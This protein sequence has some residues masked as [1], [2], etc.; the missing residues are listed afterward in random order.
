MLLARAA[1][2]AGKLK[3]KTPG[4]SVAGLWFSTLRLASGNR[5]LMG[6]HRFLPRDGEP[7]P[8]LSGARAWPLRRLAVTPASIQVAR[9]DRPSSSREV[10]RL[11]PFRRARHCRR[12]LSGY[13]TA[14]AVKKA[15]R[16]LLEIVKR[17]DTAKGLIML[18]PNA[19]LEPL[20]P[21]RQGLREPCPFRIAP[22]SS[23]P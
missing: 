23:S 19:W 22:S 12:R 3:K 2:D 18:S 5:W 14:A 10:R 15:A 6:R 16:L 9:S 4:T 7:P 13:A 20:P 21:A 8:L 11:F 1:Q 17:S